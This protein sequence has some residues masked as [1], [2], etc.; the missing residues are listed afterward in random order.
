[1]NL[2]GPCPQLLP[3]GRALMKD[4]LGNGVVNDRIK[5]IKTEV[6]PFGDL[7]VPD[8]CPTF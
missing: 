3:N 6:K 2:Q 5:S 8:E 1:M 7:I 4:T